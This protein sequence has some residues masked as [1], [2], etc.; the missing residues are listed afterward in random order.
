M[1]KIKEKIFKNMY[2]ELEVDSLLNKRN[3]KK[4]KSNIKN[5]K[6]VYGQELNKKATLITLPVR[7]TSSDTINNEY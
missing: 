7:I 1:I 5:F 6:N 3:K 4:F 2:E